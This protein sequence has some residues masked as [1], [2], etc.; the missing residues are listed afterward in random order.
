MGGESVLI[1]KMGR[2]GCVGLSTAGADTQLTIIDRDGAEVG[3]DS[4]LVVASLS[5]SRLLVS[6]SFVV[7]W[8]Y[9]Y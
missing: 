9:D 6:F 3:S 1:G 5:F 2:L 8:S 4:L 7:V